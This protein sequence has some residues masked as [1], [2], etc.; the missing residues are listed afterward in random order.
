M[1]SFFGK[2]GHSL[3][4][5]GWSCCSWRLQVVGGSHL[6]RRCV[7]GGLRRR[8][9]R[10][11]AQGIIRGAQIL[12]ELVRF[13]AEAVLKVTRVSM[14]SSTERRRCMRC[15]DD[16]TYLSALA[17]KVPLVMCAFSMAAAGRRQ[18][19]C[20]RGNGGHCCDVAVGVCAAISER[21][22]GGGWQA[23]GLWMR[24]GRLHS[25]HGRRSQRPAGIR[26]TLLCTEVKIK[27]GSSWDRVG[28]GVSFADRL[29]T[30]LD[31][32]RP[33]SLMVSASW[34]ELGWGRESSNS[35]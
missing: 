35:I 32:R 8:H 2:H 19:R 5:F 26:Q 16:A 23:E 21:D 34:A 13:L 9:I 17:R 11:W 4:V 18:C 20:S 31:V 10:D 3:V 33:L 27:E 24:A 15:T 29:G 22:M 30:S 7:P 12:V 1:L 6:P 28:S 25:I 14:F